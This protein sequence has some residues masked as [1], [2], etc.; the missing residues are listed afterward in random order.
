M[1]ENINHMELQKRQNILDKIDKI[2]N[3]LF[4]L[5]FEHDLLN[6]PHLKTCDTE[7]TGLWW[8]YQIKEDEVRK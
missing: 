6:N 5:G 3:L 7:I 2:R 1:K 4:D 8:S